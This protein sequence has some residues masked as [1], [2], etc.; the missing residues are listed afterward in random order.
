[1]I[2]IR[3]SVG[4]CSINKYPFNNYCVINIEWYQLT[5]PTERKAGIRSQNQ[6]VAI[7]VAR[8]W[9]PVDASNDDENQYEGHVINDLLF[10]M[11]RQCSTP[12]NDAFNLVEDP[13]FHTTDI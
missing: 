3:P 2:Q 9:Q 5:S 12:Y 7:C 11:I 10:D 6:I 4:S 8:N 13:V 1:M